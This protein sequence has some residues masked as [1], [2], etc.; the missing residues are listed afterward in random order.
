M[1]NYLPYRWMTRHCGVLLMLCSLSF[2]AFSQTIYVSPSG[3]D[4]T[5]DGSAANPYQ[6]IT[7]GIAM[8]A[9][10]NTIQ[11]GSGTYNELVV[12]DKSVTIDG[13]SASQATVAYTGTIADYSTTGTILPTL[14]KVTAQ[15]VEI[16]NI[17]FVVNNNVVHTAIHTSGDASGL[18]VLNNLITASYSGLPPL[19]VTALT[20]LAYARK[21]AI[22]INPNISYGA[23]KYTFVNT[24]ISNIKIAGNFISGTTQAMNGWLDVNFRAGVYAD[25]VSALVVGGTPAEKNIL[26]TV[27]HDVLARFCMDGDITIR[28][29]E[30]NGGGV[31]I[32]TI[33]GAAGT[34]SIDSNYFNYLPPVVPDFALVRLMSNSAGKNTVVKGNTFYNHNWFICLSN[35]NTVLV[36]SNIFT[37]VLRDPGTRTDFRLITVNSKAIQSSAISK[38]A[39][40]ATF[41]RNQFNG[42]PGANGT[43]I[44]FYNH[45]APATLG[46]YIVGETGRENTFNA[47]IARFLY[48]DNSNGVAT[49]ALTSTYP[50]YGSGIFNTTTAYW[51][52]NIL[53]S[54]NHYDIGAGAPLQ[55]MLMDGAQRATLEGMIVDQLD[56]ANI[57][58]VV[59]YSSTL[60]LHP[61]GATPHATQP[62]WG[63][64]DIYPNPVAAGLNIQVNTRKKQPVLARVFNMSGVCLKTVQQS[65][66]TSISVDMAGYPAGVYAIELVTTEGSIVRQVLKR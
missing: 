39:N 22:A 14:F 9:P 40:N 47:D 3:N 1:Q 34:I 42:T 17:N 7:Q 44:A 64:V 60:A 31:E 66:N 28:N 48:V 15:N 5:G 50:E 56:D 30:L 4:A 12:I 55:P 62:E 59:L 35:Y 18:R 65:S 10:G 52:R 43:G 11:L 6:T 54:Q 33:N 41:T 8:A 2:P 49:N 45:D 46:M 29:N 57:G 27:N 13:V 53:A 37:P 26:Q 19:N 38:V 58:L 51:T 16:R 61:R 21:N 63:T 20:A 24:G 36:D 23:S 32:S 25:N